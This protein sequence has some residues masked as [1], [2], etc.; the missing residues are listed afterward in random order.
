[1]EITLYDYEDEGVR[2][3]LPIP[4]EDAACAARFV[5]S[6][7]EEVRLVG[8]DGNEYVMDTGALKFRMSSFFDDFE[9]IPLEDFEDYFSKRDGKQPYR[10]YAAPKHSCPPVFT[11]FVDGVPIQ[12]EDPLQ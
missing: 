9:F 2:F 6:G 3:V 4:L 1:M 10:S 11:H 12:K 8:K 7:D 5:L